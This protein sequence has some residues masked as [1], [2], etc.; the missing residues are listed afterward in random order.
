MTDVST[1]SLLEVVAESCRGDG[2]LTPRL[3]QQPIMQRLHARI[4]VPVWNQC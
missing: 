1:P 2:R 3:H 4:L